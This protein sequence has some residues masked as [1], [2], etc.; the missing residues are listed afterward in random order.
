M[1]ITVT[2]AT[3]G[4]GS[5]LVHALQERGDEVTALTRNPAS[6]R[7]RLGDDIHAVRWEPTSGPAPAAALEYRD[8]VVNLA[9]ESLAQRWSPEVKA[10]VRSSRVDGTRNLVAGIAS[11]EGEARPVALI[12]GSAIGFYGDRREET[13]ETVPAG[14]GFLAD[15]ASAWETEARAAEALGLR[16]VLMRTG[17][18][19]EADEGVLPILVKITKLGI[20]GPLGGGKQAFPWIHVTDEVGLILHAIDSHRA[21]GPI[22]AVAPGIVTQ[23]QFGRALGRAVHRPAFMPAPAFAVRALR[24]EMADLILEG[25]RAVPTVARD[26]GYTFAFPELPSALDDLLHKKRS[27]GRSGGSRTES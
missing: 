23:A 14:T 4:I 6:A 24:G 16:V 2:G 11:T 3:G 8:A 9:G 13:D 21:N 10:R 7:E 5:R 27:E 1:R 26:L 20:M 18:V 17:D 25:A 22:N 19:L 15:I 12:S